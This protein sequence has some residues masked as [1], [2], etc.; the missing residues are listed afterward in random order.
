MRSW[1]EGEHVPVHVTRRAWMALIALAVL[2]ALVA[3]ASDA[4][5]QVV[6]DGMRRSSTRQTSVT[7]GDSFEQRQQLDGGST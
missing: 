3:Y 7:C 1:G 4:P 5:A 2:L 6:V